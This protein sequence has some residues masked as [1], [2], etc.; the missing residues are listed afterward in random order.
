MAALK[1]AN[2]KSA[3][4][5][6]AEKKAKPK[7][8]AHQLMLDGH[9]WDRSAVMDV[10]CDKLATSSKGLGTILS[11]G[12]DGLT[13]PSF[14]TVMKW[15][16]EDS[17]LSDRYARAKEAQAEYMGEEFLEL[18]EKAWVPVMVDG[19]PLVVDGKPVMTV[20]RASASAVKLEADNKKWLMSKLK[21]K[22]YGDKIAIG[23]AEDL[24]PIQQN[25]T[26][27]LTPEEAYKAM[28]NGGS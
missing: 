24:P 7:N 19:V 9:E 13:L 12:H 4:K 28:L 26:V 8:P 23:G 1:N 2:K 17:K 3:T 22:K 21:P 20:N 11:G 6:P 27:T 14:S 25:S 5:K 10:V 16:E 15:M 18:H